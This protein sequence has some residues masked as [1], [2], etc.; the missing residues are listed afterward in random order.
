MPELN[1]FDRIVGRIAGAIYSEINTKFPHPP[2]LLVPILTFK[3]RKILKAI[4]YLQRLSPGEKSF[5]AN[6]IQKSIIP[7]LD[8]FDID[9]ELISTITPLI[10]SAAYNALM[11]ESNGKI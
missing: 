6:N 11:E 1:D 3:V 8:T 2:L 10:E 5:L 7:A 4:A 9:A